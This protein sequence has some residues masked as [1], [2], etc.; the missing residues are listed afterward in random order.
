MSDTILT[1]D[2]IIKANVPNRP[3]LFDPGTLEWT[4]WVMEGSYFKLLNI[5]ETTG[6]FTVILKIDPG[7]KAPVH[8]HIGGIEVYVIEG[9]FG[10]GDDD[11]GEAGHYALE[12]GGSIHAP[13]SPDGVTMFVVVYGSIVG[14]N[15]DGSVAMVIDGRFMYDLAV[16]NNSADHITLINTFT[17]D[18]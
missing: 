5:N 4:D 10:Y 9:E 3:A 16:K 7:I 11:R 12:A 2:T 17:D 15:E 6:G 18:V 13:S 8:H 14:Y 1:T